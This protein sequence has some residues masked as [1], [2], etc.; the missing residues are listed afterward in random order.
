[1]FEEVAKPVVEG[2]FIVSL[3]RIGLLEGFNGTIFCYGQ[4]G[5]GKTFTMEVRFELEFQLFR[6]QTYIMRS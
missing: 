4:T 3:L 6:V 5:R 2:T 1:M